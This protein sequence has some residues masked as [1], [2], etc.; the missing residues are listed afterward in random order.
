M[1]TL[2]DIFGI[3]IDNKQ[4]F[5]CA[6]THPSYAIEHNLP[7]L[8]HYERLEFLGDAV[9]KYT[10]S[11]IMFELYPD[12]TEGQLTKI[13]SVIV[14]DNMLAKICKELKMHK[15]I[16]LAK[17][18]ES[19]GFRKLESI[20]ACAFEAVLGAF[21]LDGKMSELMEF[22]KRVF[23]PHIKNINDYP[24]KY[25]AKAVL[26]EY[27]QG[28]SK[29]IPVYRLVST[30]GPAHD[31]TFNIEVSY[32]G[33]LIGKGHGKTKKEAEQMAALKACNKLGVIQC[34]KL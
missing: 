10:V 5:E 21:C 31:T 2:E 15:L 25:N 26:Q 19:H 34:S 11:V 30:D 16:K 22:M 3:K 9:L 33:K 17:N 23:I 29:E 13:R 8:E 32:K 1:K 7:P 18:E 12:Y 24:E 28:M 4:L 14:S 20:K 6:L 27:T